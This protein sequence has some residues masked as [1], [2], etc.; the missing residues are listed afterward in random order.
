MCVWVVWEVVG[1]GLDRHA[2]DL[3]GEMEVRDKEE[4]AE[5]GRESFLWDADLP[6]G[7][8]EESDRAQ[9]SERF[10]QPWAKFAWQR[11]VIL[12]PAGLGLHAC[13]HSGLCTSMVTGRGGSS[14]AAVTCAPCSRFSRRRSEPSVGYMCRKYIFHRAGYLFT[15]LM[16]YFDE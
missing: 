8:R 9:F 15:L 6:L 16:V 10:I 4:R 3:L 13:P 1:S 5:G 12:P 2:R 7:R 11:N 14:W